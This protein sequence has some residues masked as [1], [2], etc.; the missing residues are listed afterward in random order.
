MSVKVLD[1][2]AYMLTAHI[3]L[4]GV[5]KTEGEKADGLHVD[6]MVARLPQ[7]M[8]VDPQKLGRSL[9]LLGTEHWYVTPCSRRCRYLV[10]Y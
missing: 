10:P 1:Q 8:K 9:R 6:E 2:T 5:F 7:G 3:D 4:L